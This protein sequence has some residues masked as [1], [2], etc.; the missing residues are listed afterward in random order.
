M[1]MGLDT[2]YA[3]AERAVEAAKLDTEIA[4]TEYATVRNS[5]KKKKVSK[6]RQWVRPVLIPN[7]L[8]LL[9]SPQRRTPTKRL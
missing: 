9:S 2:D 6:V 3:E 7:L 8:F 1:Q 4:K 5:E